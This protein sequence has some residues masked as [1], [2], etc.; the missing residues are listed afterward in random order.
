[1]GLATTRSSA[2]PVSTSFRPARVTTRSTETSDTDPF[3]HGGDGDDYVDGGSG[4]DILYGDNGDDVVVGGSDQDQL[5]GNDGDDILLPGDPTG[6]LT[7]GSDEVLGGD[8]VDVNDKGFDL[9]SFSDNNA[10][11]NGVTFDIGNQAN[12]NVTVNGSPAQVPTYQID[13]VVGSVSNDKLVGDDESAAGNGADASIAGK[14]WLIGGSGD[15]SF[16]GLGGNDIIV[17][18]S[19]RLD[20][21]IGKYNSGYTHNIDNAG[22]TDAEQQL[23]ARYQGASHRVDYSET[24]DNS[25]LLGHSQTNMF[26][27]RFTEML[28]AEMFKDTMLGDGGTDGTADTA[29]YTGTINIDSPNQSDYTVVAL[30]AQGG[31]VANPHANGFFALKITDNRTANDFIDANGDPIVDAN[32][33]PLTNEGTDLVVGVEN[34]QFANGTIKTA[35]LFDKA[36]TV[37]LNYVPVANLSVVASDNFSG[38]PINNAYGRGTGW[39]GSWTELNDGR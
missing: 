38:L 28:R 9:I 32:G 16:Q 34:L 26:E 1:M 19:I 7:I 14:N 10:R 24:V 5:F 37:D 22:L 3:T 39:N 8:G 17:G 13:G 12:P 23:D 31:V 21:L 33:N 6:A 4:G 11:P 2:E 35:A 20:A 27:K 30:N 15:D 29:I 18:G 36:P 25:G